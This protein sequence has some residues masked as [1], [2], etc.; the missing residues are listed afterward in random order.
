MAT[1][2]LAGENLLLADLP[3]LLISTVLLVVLA[4]ALLGVRRMVSGPQLRDVLGISATFVVLCWFGWLMIVGE[5]VL[6]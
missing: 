2:L 4:G 3:L 6:G 5:H 1:V